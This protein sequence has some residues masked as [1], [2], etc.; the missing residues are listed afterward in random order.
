[1]SIESANAFLERMKTDEDFRKEVS[2]IKDSGGRMKFVKSAGFDFTKEEIVSVRV[3]LTDYE[4]AVGVGGGNLW[5]SG[6]CC[7]AEIRK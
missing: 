7:I 4:P 5:F 2:E 3:Q 1:M 6:L